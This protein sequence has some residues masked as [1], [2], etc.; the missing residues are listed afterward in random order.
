MAT[1]KPR[2]QHEKEEVPRQEEH[3]MTECFRISSLLEL[4]GYRWDVRSQI[5]RRISSF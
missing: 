2:H 5:I 4:V 1:G 3:D